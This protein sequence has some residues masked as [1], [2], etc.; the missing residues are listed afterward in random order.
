VTAAETIAVEDLEET[1]RLAAEFETMGGGALT[2]ALAHE[3]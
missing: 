3:A 1:N 2:M